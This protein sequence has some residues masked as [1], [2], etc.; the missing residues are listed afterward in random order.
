MEKINWSIVSEFIFDGARF[1]S[2]LVDNTSSPQMVD[3]IYTMSHTYRD[4]YQVNNWKTIQFSDLANDV[5]N[6][7]NHGCI[8]REGCQRYKVSRKD[9][10]F[11]HHRINWKVR[12]QC[13]DKKCVKYDPIVLKYKTRLERAVKNALADIFK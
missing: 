6:H 7:G 13:E 9:G 12:D 4:G 11:L 5:S 10:Y 2:D 3:T 8:R 1:F